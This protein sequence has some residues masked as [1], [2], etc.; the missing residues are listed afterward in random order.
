[1]SAALAIQDVSWRTPRAPDLRAVQGAV[2]ADALANLLAGLGGALMNSTRSS[3]VFLIRNTQVSARSVGLVFG[4][5]LVAFA[6]LP[7]VAALVLALP[8]SVLGAYLAIMIA[9]LF[10]TGMKLVVSEGLDYRRILITG[11]S[12]WVGAGCQYGLLLPDILPHIAGGLLNNGLTAGGITAI[13]MTVLLEFTGGRRRKLETDLDVSS[14]PELREF[15]AQFGR[16]GGWSQKMLDRLD[17][18][19]E[20]TLLT[21]VEDQPE[22]GAV[23][24]RLRV[25]AH[26]ESGGAV[27]EFVAKSSDSNIED[28][29]AFLGDASD[30]RPAE[31]D[32]S[33]HLLRHLA[34][35]V[36]HRQY[37]DIDLITVRVES[38]RGGPRL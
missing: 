26:S 22:A 36:R 33:L 10:V 28:R 38:S 16:D 8:P 20:E 24:R 14:L 35:E 37:H 6:F 17:A 7:K 3:T 27:L 29:I 11:I 30:A 5:A 12:F 18:V 21:L 31:R 9:T 34:S 2:A 19:A 13:S 23:T 1:M 32:I 15:V 25:S 4:C